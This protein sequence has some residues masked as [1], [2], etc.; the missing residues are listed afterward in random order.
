MLTHLSISHY[1]GG[2]LPWPNVCSLFCDLAELE[3]LH[4]GGIIFPGRDADTAVL[5]PSTLQPLPRLRSLRIDR[6]MGYGNLSDS[7]LSTPFAGQLLRA[8]L[9]GAPN[10]EE[11]AVDHTTLY[12]HEHW[13]GADGSLAG[14][15]PT[16]TRLSLGSFHLEPGA[17]DACSLP[18]LRH[19]RLR[20]AGANAK[21]LAMSLLERCSCL[22][23][24]DILFS[25]RAVDDKTPDMK[26]SDM[27][28]D[29]NVMIQ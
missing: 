9:A 20:N 4:I 14:L 3:F 23:A 27:Q 18:R 25:I 11:F 29:S 28:H 7:H 26:L 12:N 24:K 10:I 8:L 15:P 19:L 6:L 13:P 5:Y 22:S 21:T 2:C 1:S 16:I 17:F